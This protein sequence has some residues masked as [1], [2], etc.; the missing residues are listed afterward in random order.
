MDYT[1]QSVFFKAAKVARYIRLYGFSRT[2]MK[3]I[4]Q[5]HMKRQFA[6][7]PPRNR[8][9]SSRQ[10]VGLIGCGNYAFSNIA[11][12]LNKHAGRVFAA[13]M[14]RNLHRAA[15]LSRQYSIPYYTDNAED[16]ITD[17]RIRLLYIASNHASHA[18]YAIRGLEAGKDVY[19]EKP[20]VVSEDQLRRLTEAMSF[21]DGKVFLGFNRPGS[22]F[23]RMILRSL[24]GE[25]G[26]GMYSWFVAGHKIDADHW[27]FRPEEGGRVL[28]NLCHWTDFVLHMAGDSPFPV[29]VKPT[30]AQKSDSDIAVSYT[31]PDETIAVIT[32]SAKGHT[33]EGVH[34]SL[35]AHRGDCLISMQ[36]YKRLLV[37]RGRDKREVLNRFRDHGHARNIVAAYRAS[38]NG[39]PYDRLANRRYIANTAWLFLKTREALETDRTLVVDEYQLPAGE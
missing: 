5:L 24:A 36:D 12:F 34:E 17:P 27:Y 16:L 7:L 3:V 11:Y 23:G 26:A 13:C 33:F 4:A 38:A 32:F 28:G 8:N 35:S 29:I 39:L 15:S 9:Y 10:T 18:E 20:H 2:R 31:F 19:I 22:D 37:Q 21:N 30:R 25:T 14:D 1:T 6:Q